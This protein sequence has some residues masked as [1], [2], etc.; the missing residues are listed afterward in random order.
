MK[1]QKQLQK[2]KEEADTIIDLLQAMMKLNHK[3]CR[4]QVL[5]DSSYAIKFCNEM[6]INP[7]HDKELWVIKHDILRG[8][9][10]LRGRIA[11]D[12]SEAIEYFTKS[13]ESLNEANKYLPPEMKLYL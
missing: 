6:K 13:I 10:F 2:Y 1:K 4:E 11:D 12:P 3:A 7:R 5:Q 8:A 9:Y